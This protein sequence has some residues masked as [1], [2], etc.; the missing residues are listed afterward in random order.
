MSV[1]RQLYQL[2]E[3]ELELE[4]NEQA[5][6]QITRQLGESEAVIETRNKLASERQ[7]L[8]ELTHQQNSVEWDIDDITG[9][10]TAVE[11]ELYSGKIRNPKELTNL[12][13]EIDSLKV[14]RNQLEDQTLEVMERV[15]SATKSVAALD[16][17]LKRLEVEWQSQQQK[18]L[19]NLEQL[20]A[21]ISKLKHK[22]ELLATEIDS[23]LVG[24]YHEIKKQR[25]TAVAKVEQGICHGCRIS[26][27]VTELQ[28]AR[29]G[30]LVRCSSCG[31]ILFLA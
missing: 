15:E 20:K 7:H 4:S 5:L 16:R 26:L 19:A 9:K 10:L 13:Q 29:S 11:E 18:L 27:P 22:R 28:R 12:Q 14:K 21:V 25:G 24:V 1:T 23:Q 30:S 31:R 6:N 17:E 8:E 2:Q 3:V